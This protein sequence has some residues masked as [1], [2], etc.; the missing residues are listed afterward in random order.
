L[1]CEQSGERACLTRAAQ[2]ENMLHG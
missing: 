1:C 2:Q